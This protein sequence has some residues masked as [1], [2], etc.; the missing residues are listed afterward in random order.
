MSTTNSADACSADVLYATLDEVQRGGGSQVFAPIP[1]FHLYKTAREEELLA[2]RSLCR[3]VAMHYGSLPSASSKTTESRSNG[4]VSLPKH[5]QR[6]LEDLR[7][8]W[9][10]TDERADLEHSMAS[11]DEIVQGIH[12]SNVLRRRADFFDGVE[13]VD[14][15]TVCG[16]AAA[17]DDGYLVHAKRQ[18]L[19]VAGG[20][21]DGIPP[22]Y[23]TDYNADRANGAPGGRSGVTSPPTGG[24][25]AGAGA[26]AVGRRRNPSTALFQQLSRI[27]RDVE[28][29]A[30]NHLYSTDPVSQQEALRT[31]EAKRMELLNLHNE[32]TNEEAR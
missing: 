30:R 28:T 16:S 23:G 8:E 20:G 26:G 10:I 9:C 32:L 31:L 15:A 29:A 1:A 27:K 11:E 7:E 24:R 17:A 3:V 6:I 21:G 13:D 5:M 4:N 2:Y 19:E 22:L 14:V 18:R 25:G 12:H